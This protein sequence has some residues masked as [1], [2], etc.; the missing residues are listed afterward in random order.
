MKKVII[1]GGGVAGFAAG[2]YLQHNGYETVILEK[3]AVAGGACIGWERSGCYIDGCI[4]WLTGVKKGTE[5]NKIWLDTGALNEDTQI[6][7]QDDLIHMHFKD[8]SLTIWKD[9]AKLEAEL[10]AFAPEDAKEIKNFVKLI[11]KFQKVNPPAFKPVELMNLSDLL[12]VAFTMGG[13]YY[14]VAKMSKISC[15]DYAKRFKNQYLRELIGD[16]MAPHYNLMSMLYMLGHISAD[17]GGIPV[18]GSLEMVKRM[19]ERYVSLGGKIRKAVSVTEVIINDNKAEGVVLKNGE[20]I[21]ADWVVSTTPV[22]HCLN[23]LLGGKYHDKQFDM[24]IKNQKDYPI[25]TFTTAVLKCPN[26]IANKELS[27]KLVTDKPI[28]IDKTYNQLAYRN[29]AY[30]ST[31]KGSDEFCV[32]QATIHSDDNMYFWWKERKADG[33]YKQEKQRVGNELLE[34]AKEIHKDVADQIEVIDVVTPC[35]Y[36]RYLNS[37]HGAFQG[38]V[39]TKRG[40]SL[41]HNGR[42]KGLKNFLISGQYTIQSGGLPPAA[43]SGRFV[44]QRICH[45]DKK[46]FVDI[47]K[48]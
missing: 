46:K 18:G 19:E 15:K 40:K 9:P 44:A 37:R 12:K 26:T 23:E 25:Y 31:L 41:M 10:I 28:T 24:R 20:R 42:I 30:D 21:M 34:I 1:I 2:T 8:K 45:D 39:H 32:V 4:H 7:Y 33:T 14:W 3:N 38:F 48:K 29:Y 36:E 22:E 43:M 27:V 6:F 11:R 17:D 47:S 16:F 35:T 13:S 5:F